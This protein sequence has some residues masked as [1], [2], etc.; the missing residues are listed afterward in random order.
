MFTLLTRSNPVLPNVFLF[1]TTL[2][3]LGSEADSDIFYSGSFF[4]IFPQIGSEESGRLLLL[5]QLSQI[6]HNYHK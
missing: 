2:F 1:R 4:S 3:D 6:I 5:V